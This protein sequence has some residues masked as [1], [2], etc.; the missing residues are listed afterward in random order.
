MQTLD[1]RTVILLAGFMGA[2]MSLVLIFLQR[3]ALNPV[4]GLR[5]WSA[6]ALTGVFAAMLLGARGIL[7]DFL[8]IVVGNL[9]LLGGVCLF[10]IGTRRFF[11]LDARISRFAGIVVAYY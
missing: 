4:R 2:L 8:T 11:S 10:S 7:P 6:A 1:L 5:E 9:F 3:S